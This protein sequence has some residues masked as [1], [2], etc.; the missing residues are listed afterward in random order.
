[1]K[2]NHLFGMFAMAAFSFASCSQ[3]EV[4]TQ[5]PE[6]NKAIEF[7][8]YVGRDAVSR[9]HV[10][11]INKL[12]S[13]G[14]GVFAYYTG[15]DNFETDITTATPNFMYNQKVTSTS[16]AAGEAD[17][18]GVVSWTG[19]WVY[20]PVKYW[21]NNVDDKVSFFA[22]APYDAGSGGNFTLPLSNAT[23]VP[24][25]TFAVSTDDVEDHQDLLWAA[26]VMNQSKNSDNPVNI[27]SKVNFDFKHALA[28]IGF[29]AEVL[30]DKVNTDGTGQADGTNIT[31]VDLDAFTTIT[32]KS[33]K[34]I[35]KFYSQGT[36]SLKDGTWSSQETPANAVTFEL[37]NTT[38]SDFASRTTPS[39]DANIFKSGDIA[40]RQ[41][42]NDENYIMIIPQNFTANGDAAPGK[43]KMVVEYEVFT[44]LDKDGTLDANDSKV[45]NTITSEEFAL[46]FVQ[47]NAYSLN[48][49]IGMTSV[50]FSATVQNWNEVG[51]WAVNV[52]LNTE[53]QTPAPA[54]EPA[55]SE[56]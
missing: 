12:A 35:G 32:I 15:G 37:N 26:P 42:N 22:Y 34:L 9:G 27:D 31:S 39:D 4:V 47:G 29:K 50:K 1:M 25:L 11:T 28:R 45:T 17:G 10:T 16:G 13:E 33:V 41:L 20:T 7:G 30:V 5:S 38:T 56:S 36:M 24:S 44:D 8:T 53:T 40:I 18:N 6:V 51:D 21:P 46:N 54:P 3:D 19:D 23:G 55:G 48:I 2:K 43:L 52:P 14:F 49:H